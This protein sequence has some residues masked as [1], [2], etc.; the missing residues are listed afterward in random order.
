MSEMIVQSLLLL[1]GSVRSIIPGLGKNRVTK[2]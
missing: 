2:V 1:M